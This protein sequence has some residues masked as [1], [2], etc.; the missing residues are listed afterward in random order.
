MPEH[1][2]PLVLHPVSILTRPEG[3]M[4]S[5]SAPRYAGRQ[6]VSILTRPEGRMLFKSCGVASVMRRSFNPHPA[7]RPDAIVTWL[8]PLPG[9]AVSILTRPEGRMLSRSS[10]RLETKKAIVSIL[11]RPEGRMLF[12][13]FHEG[14]ADK[15]EFQSSPGPKAGCYAHP[16]GLEAVGKRFNPHPAR[17]PDAMMGQLMVVAS[18]GAFQSSPGPKAGC[19]VHPCCLQSGGE[20]GFNPH[21]ARRPDAIAGNSIRSIR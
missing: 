18:V 5:A 16:G 15:I 8:R 2:G 1:P 4:L 13:A 19:Y 14:E 10:D 12:Y 21:P 6:D 17:R 20:R 3:R 7:R 9:G 11:T